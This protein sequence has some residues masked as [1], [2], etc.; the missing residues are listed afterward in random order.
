MK[1]DLDL[2]REILLELESWP[3]ELEWRVVNIEG[4]RPDEIDAHVLIMADAG[5][6]KASVL[7]TDRG[8]VLERIRVLQLTWHGH[9]FL[10]DMRAGATDLDS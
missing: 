3:A 4:R 8:Q 6:V 1:R 7:G 9:D 5:L 2:V 10:D